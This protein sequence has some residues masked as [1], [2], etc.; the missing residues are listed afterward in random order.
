[1]AEQFTAAI[2]AFA[3]DVVDRTIE[4]VLDDKLALDHTVYYVNE[5]N[6]ATGKT[7]YKIVYVPDTV[8]VAAYA[9]DDPVWAFIQA[10]LLANNKLH[11]MTRSASTDS[12]MLDVAGDK[13]EADGDE[14]EADGEKT[15]VDAVCFELT[16]M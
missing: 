12:I 11:L 13:T 7:G 1:M 2:R 5:K 6:R 9:N 15:E 8:N 16:V 14:P 4:V 10:F 3:L